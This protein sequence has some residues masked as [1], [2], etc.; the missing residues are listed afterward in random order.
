MPLGVTACTR[1]VYNAFLSDDRTKALFHGHSYT[2]NATAC[3]AAIASMEFLLKQECQYQIFMISEMNKKF[4]DKIKNHASVTD[5]RTMATILA[6]ELKTEAGT[7]Y[8]SNLRDYLYNF[9]MTRKILMRPLGNIIYIIPPYC[10]TSD[11]LHTTY[12]AIE[13]L[14]KTL[15]KNE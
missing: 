12:T 2:A 7:S 15:N 6:I 1:E 8:F 11:Q 13:E 14:L 3:A 10:T 4:A 5:V 9:F